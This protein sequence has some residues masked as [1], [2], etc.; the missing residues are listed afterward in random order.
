MPKYSSKLL[1]LITVLLLLPAQ[2]FA[3]DDVHTWF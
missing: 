2:L 1:G 3:E